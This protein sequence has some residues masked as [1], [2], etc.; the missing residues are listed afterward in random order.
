MCRWGLSSNLTFP[1]STLTVK[2]V[3]EA[4][5]RKIVV[6]P[7]T[8]EDYYNI[9]D[10]VCQLTRLRSYQLADVLGKYKLF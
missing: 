7:M 3:R 8:L 1:I 6:K 4:K 2:E 5:V 10:T 9:A